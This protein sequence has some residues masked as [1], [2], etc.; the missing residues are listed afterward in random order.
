MSWRTPRNLKDLVDWLIDQCS[1]VSELNVIQQGVSP[2]PG[3]TKKGWH[4][5]LNA[6]EVGQEWE[7]DYQSFRRDMQEAV[8]A[9]N[10]R[11]PFPLMWEGGAVVG[12]VYLG[13]DT[14][15][16]AGD[17]TLV[18]VLEDRGRVAGRSSIASLLPSEAEAAEQLQSVLDRSGF[19]GGRY[20]PDLK[21]AADNLLRGLAKQ[22]Y[23]VRRGDKASLLKTAKGGPGGGGQQLRVLDRDGLVLVVDLQWRLRLPSNSWDVLAFASPYAP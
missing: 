7:A 2:L 20:F 12:E 9:C 8:E 13:R 17:V 3:S 5:R 22:D 10:K 14:D 18:F 16:R 11:A 6:P 15:W 1:E 21:T 4:L 19:G 23:E